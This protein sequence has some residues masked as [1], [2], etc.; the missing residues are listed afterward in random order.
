MQKYIQY[1]NKSIDFPNQTVRN[2]ELENRYFKQSQWYKETQRNRAKNRYIF[3][4][5]GLVKPGDGSQIHHVNGNPFDNRM[6]NL[7]VVRNQ[8]AHNKL[9]GKTCTSKG[10]KK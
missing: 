8:C 6:S 1:R 7:V 4:K 5:K 10:K 9:H 3:E 2:Y